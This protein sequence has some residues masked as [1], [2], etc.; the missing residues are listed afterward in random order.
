MKKRPNKGQIFD[1]TLIQYLE[2]YKRW[3]FLFPKQALKGSIF[4]NYQKMAK[5]P[6]HFIS[7]Q[8]FQKGQMATLEESRTVE[9]N[10][11][12]R[13]EVQATHVICGLCLLVLTLRGMK[14]SVIN[15]IIKLVFLILNFVYNC[16]QF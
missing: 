10:F 15:Y 1:E 6:N 14:M 7:S 9:R 4:Y 11:G 5:K 16:L 3:Y 13:L 2:F 8:Q 12:L